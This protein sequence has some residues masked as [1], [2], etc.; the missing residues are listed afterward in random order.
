M[1]IKLA[2]FFKGIAMGAA[3]I[4]PGVSG[5]TIAL[6]TGIYEELIDSIKNISF[7]LF[8]IL[9]TDGFKSFWKDLNG[10]FLLTL[11]SGILL[12]ILLLAQF[13][14]YLL[15]NHEFKIWGFFFGL[16]L[17]SGLFLY[18]QVNT[19][20]SS[21]FI[22]LSFGFLLS[23]IISLTGPT[24]TPNNYFFVFFTGSIA[25]CAM[26]L[27]GIS[28]SF[29]LLLL[30]KYEYIIN[31]IKDLKLDVLIVFSIGCIFGLLLFSR[32]LSYLFTNYKNTVLSVLSGFLFG[33]LIKVWPFRRIIETRINSEG[34][35]EPFITRPALPE[36]NNIEEI[37]FFALFTFLGYFLIHFLQKNSI[38]DNK[39]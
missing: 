37:T 18:R 19:L 6:I 3:D 38:E 1:K 34:V 21:S 25:I 15:V 23:S 9:F 39:E 28:G 10:N 22:Y 29:I 13:I 2:L 20:S 16:I 30:S 17:S 4:V 24:S 12:S 33:S 5:G 36:I 11:A 27:P 26:I 14:S 8:K 31:A 32:F 35:V 7:R